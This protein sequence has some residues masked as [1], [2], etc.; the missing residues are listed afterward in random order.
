MNIFFPEYVV[1]GVA[2]LIFG[3]QRGRKLLRK[4]KA[5]SQSRFRFPPGP[6]PPALIP[7]RRFIEHILF[8]EL[9]GRR[10]QHLGNFINVLEAHGQEHGDQVEIAF[11][12]YS[13]NDML[14]IV[15]HKR[16][17][18]N[19]ISL[20]LND[21]TK[22]VLNPSNRKIYTASPNASSAAFVVSIPV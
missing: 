17:L 6:F 8:V 5:D 13:G 16:S 10:P 15:F 20:F 4:K 3:Y 21:K 18:P 19:C 22:K 7:L 11:L 14:L 12:P 2:L 9:H 1:L